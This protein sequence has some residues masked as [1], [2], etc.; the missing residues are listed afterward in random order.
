MSFGVGTRYISTIACVSFE[1]V[2]GLNT[3]LSC[4]RYVSSSLRPI[5]SSD[6]KCNDLDLSSTMSSFSEFDIFSMAMFLCVF[7]ALEIR[8]AIRVAWRRCAFSSSAEVLF[9]RFMMDEDNSW[10]GPIEW[11]AEAR[12]SKP[13]TIVWIP[14]QRFESDKPLV[15]EEEEEGLY[16]RKAEEELEEEEDES[17]SNSIDEDFESPPIL[18]FM[19]IISAPS[20]ATPLTRVHTS[21][22]DSFE[23]QRHRSRVDFTAL[24]LSGDAFL[25]TC[26]VI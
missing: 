8:G 1:T 20:L 23:A 25:T 4:A 9:A 3:A 24:R 14:L 18:L 2:R 22:S 26:L 6:K 5:R 19:L 16:L 15:G 11:I 17:I 10:W 7:A 13:C 12:T 21:P